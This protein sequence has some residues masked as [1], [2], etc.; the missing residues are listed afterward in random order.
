MKFVIFIL[1]MLIWE[2]IFNIFV[3]YARYNINKDSLTS[4]IISMLYSIVWILC[5]IN[6]K[7]SDSMLYVYMIG[8]AQGLLSIIEIMSIQKKYRDKEWIRESFRL[9]QCRNIAFQ[10]IED[11]KDEELQLLQKINRSIVGNKD[12]TILIIAR[13]KKQEMKL[14]FFIYKHGNWGCI[15]KSCYEHCDIELVKESKRKQTIIC[16]MRSEN[17]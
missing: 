14:M 6:S 4:I 1:L 17:E 15:Q 13:G 8:V 2:V 3:K 10:W 16:C 12:K 5:V 7:I 9:N 11:F